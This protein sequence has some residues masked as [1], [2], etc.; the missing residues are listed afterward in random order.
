LESA[1][2]QSATCETLPK[3]KAAANR[4]CHTSGR[5]VSQLRQKVPKIADHVEQRDRQGE[6]KNYY[7][8]R[9]LFPIDVKVRIDLA[10]SVKEHSV[11]VKKDGN[12]FI[13]VLAFQLPV[14]TAER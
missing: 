12:R 6:P 5:L 2:L 11:L 10:S 13:P 3:Q 9:G 1:L 14:A 4:Y 7:K 8:P